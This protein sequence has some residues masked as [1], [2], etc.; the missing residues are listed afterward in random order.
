MVK[1][2]IFTGAESSGKS[3]LAARLAQAKNWP[4][5]KE[6][7]RE[8]LERHGPDYNQADFQAMLQGQVQAERAF[9]E[10]H[11]QQNRILDTDL[12]NYLVWAEWHFPDLAPSVLALWR[13]QARGYYLLC[14]PD[15][16]WEPD[17]LRE[18][19]K[20]RQAIFE[21]H[22][23]W[24]KQ[25]ALPY[26]CVKAK[27]EQRWQSLIKAIAKLDQEVNSAGSGA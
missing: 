1:T 17:P 14:S 4:Y 16:D 20:D 2:W 11:W 13:Q 19:P 10:R 24:L 8:Y 27:G 3:V 15:L 23:Y 22:R 26:R 7:A 9:L 12:L 6:Y 5:L 25:D 21:R 18:N